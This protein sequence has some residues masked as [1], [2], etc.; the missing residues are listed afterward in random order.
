MSNRKVKIMS[1]S[2]NADGVKKA[3]GQPTIDAD[4]GDKSKQQVSY[5]TFDKAMSSLNKEKQA[6]KELETQLQKIREDQMLAE[7]KKDEVIESYKQKVQSYEQT[8]KQEKAERALDRFKSKVTEVAAK[9]GFKNP[10]VAQ[11]MFSISEFELDG[12]NN[13]NHEQLESKIDEL[14]KTDAYLFQQVDQKIP[15]GQP[16]FRIPDGS[17]PTRDDLNKLSKDQLMEHLQKFK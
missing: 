11:K 8:I 14:K 9:K 17:M 3:D 2:T 5:D 1:D 13:V 15:D 10:S 7:G 16:K 12:D 6:R 4:G